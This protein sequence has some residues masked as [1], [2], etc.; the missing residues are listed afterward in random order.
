MRKSFKIDDKISSRL[1]HLEEYVFFDVAKAKKEAILSGKDIID[2][3]G[4][5][6]DLPPHP[7]IIEALKKEAENLENHRHPIYEGS[8]ESKKD[9]G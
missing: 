3:G 2:L 1:K 9:L 5:N 4:G 7:R 8:P 6:P